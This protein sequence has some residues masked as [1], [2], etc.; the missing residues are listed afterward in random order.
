MSKLH[1]SLGNPNP[2][3]SLPAGLDCDLT[4][5]QLASEAIANCTLSREQ[6]A[7][8]M[9]YVLGLQVTVIML[10]CWTAESKDRHRFPLAFLPA[11]CHATGDQRLLECVAG[12]LGLAVADA[13]RA[14]LAQLGELVMASEASGRAVDALKQQ[15][16]EDQP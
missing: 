5:R 3:G 14:R 15:L 12:K 8:H 16:A 4:L 1:Q 13:R 10:N 2:R 11:F 7:E 6:I 9:S